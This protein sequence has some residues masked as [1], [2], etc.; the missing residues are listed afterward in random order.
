MESI[1]QIG[2]HKYAQLKRM[3]EL[4]PE[5]KKQVANYEGRFA[6]PEPSEGV[7]AYYRKV[8]SRDSQ[9]DFKVSAKRLYLHFA[10]KFNEIEKKK[11]ILNDTTIEN[12]RPII[13]YFSKDQQFFECANLVTKFDFSGAK[14][15]SAPSFEKG[16]LIVGHYGNG[17]TA[18]MTA[19]SRLLINTP[20]SFM[21]HTANG[22]VEDYE[23]CNGSADKKEFWRKM[24]AK[25]IY[26]DDVKTERIASNYGKSNLI[27]DI[28]EKR[29]MNKRITHL[30][31]NYHPQYLGDVNYALWEFGEKYGGRVFDRLFEMFNVI[32]FKGKSFRR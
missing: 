26:I 18:T 25:G 16:L 1:K 9:A 27:K 11:F 20:Y 14:K 2:R 7:K 5:Q 24:D 21:H 22:V 12:I 15:D 19:L 13:Y 32:E 4:T 8:L 28:I 17:K 6:T 10:A 31:C 30:T 29:Y 3:P 23:Y